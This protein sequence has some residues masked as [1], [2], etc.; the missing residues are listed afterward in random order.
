[1]NVIAFLTMETL[2]KAGSTWKQMENYAKLWVLPAHYNSCRLQEIFARSESH[3]KVQ[4]MKVSASD[5]LT[6][7]PVFRHFVQTCGQHAG[8]PEA[9]KAFDSMCH[10]LDLLLCTLYGQNWVTG[11]VLDEAVEKA[12]HLCYQAGWQKN[13]SRSSIG[14]YTMG[15]AC[16]N[17]QHW[18]HASAW[19][20]NTRGLPL[21]LC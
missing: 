5:M 18:S 8:C 12:L 11:S 10:V 7:S 19:K 6:L 21:Q 17:I 3:R 16:R 1:M 15:T 14:A 9:C 4:K 2:H 20:E 13:L